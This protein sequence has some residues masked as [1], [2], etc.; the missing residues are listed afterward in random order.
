MIK[1]II[2][3][4]ICFSLLI[5]CSSESISRPDDVRESIWYNGESLYLE[6]KEAMNSVR[7]NNLKEDILSKET[8]LKIINYIEEFEDA[9]MGNSMEYTPKESDI[10]TNIFFMNLNY[11]TYIIEISKGNHQEAEESLNIFND[12]IMEMEEIFGK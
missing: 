11:I 1:R 12:I 5:G 6:L 10:V 3:L 4:I 2:L 7:E 8:K 9:I